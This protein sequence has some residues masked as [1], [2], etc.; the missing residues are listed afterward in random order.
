M[1]EK[2]LHEQSQRIRKTEAENI[3]HGRRRTRG[4]PFAHIVSE[5]LRRHR[6]AIVPGRFGTASESSR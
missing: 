5:S 4:M 2:A 3:K 1:Y 6:S